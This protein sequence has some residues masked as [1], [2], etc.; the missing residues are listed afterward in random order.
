MS[1][2]VDCTLEEACKLISA[3]IDDRNFVPVLNEAMA[4]G[5]PGEPVHPGSRDWVKMLVE[6]VH[7]G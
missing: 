7:Q 4:V 1:I 2:P 6:G 5:I 3:R